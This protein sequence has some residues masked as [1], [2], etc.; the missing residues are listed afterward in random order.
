MVHTTPVLT[1][2]YKSTM[3]Y[4]KVAMRKDAVMYFTGRQIRREYNVYHT[5]NRPGSNARSTES[6]LQYLESLESLRYFY[7]SIFPR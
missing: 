2:A 7:S 1:M 6:L 4:R 3:V 5:I